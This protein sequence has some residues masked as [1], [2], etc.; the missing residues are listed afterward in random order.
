MIHD[1]DV[2][3]LHPPLGGLPEAIIIELA[4]LPQAIALLRANLVPNIR[5]GKRRKLG[6]RSDPALLQ[7]LLRPFL[8]HP[9]GLQLLVVIKQITLP[10]AR[11]LEA[12]LA[13]VIAPAFAE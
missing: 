2:P 13:E 12:A 5:L 6:Q 4:L 9:K 7:T 10:S 11:L 1:K 8:D 3:R